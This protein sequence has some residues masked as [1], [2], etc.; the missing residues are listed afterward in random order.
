MIV[1]EYRHNRKFREFV[2]DFCKK[3]NMSVAEALRHKSV[4]QAWLFCTDV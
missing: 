1:N 2:N 4:K 3:N